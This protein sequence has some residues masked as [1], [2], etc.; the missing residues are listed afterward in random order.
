MLYLSNFHCLEI[1]YLSATNSKGS[2]VKIYS[3][4]F[5]QSVIVSYNYEFSTVCDIAQDYLEKLG[6]E[7]IGKAESKFG[8]YLISSTFK[9]L[10]K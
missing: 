9:P 8:Y 10:K 4:R 7:F 6:F 3:P 1:T 5:E 2:R